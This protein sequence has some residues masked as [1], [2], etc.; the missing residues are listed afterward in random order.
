MKS[1]YL[2]PLRRYRHFYVFA[3]IFQNTNFFENWA[4]YL[5]EM[6]LGQKISPNLLYLALLRRHRQFSV[7]YMNQSDLV[8]IAKIAVTHWIL[9]IGLPKRWV[10]KFQPYQC[11]CQIV[12]YKNQEGTVACS[13]NTSMSQNFCH[14]NPP[15]LKEMW[16]VAR[17]KGNLCGR[18]SCIS[19][20][21]TIKALKSQEAGPVY[22]MTQGEWKNVRVA[23]L[24]HSILNIIE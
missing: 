20:G 15:S 12:R 22:S 7:A 13:L 19:F 11:T 4:V 1:L 14:R 23:V 9:T 18:R 21:N 10:A 2:A 24:Y 17:T 16:P 8:K 5:A 3:S 6:P